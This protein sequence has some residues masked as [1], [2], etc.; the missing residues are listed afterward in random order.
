[1]SALDTIVKKFPPVTYVDTLTQQEAAAEL[2]SLRAQVAELR[3]AGQS[4]VEALEDMTTDQF[5]R[6]MDKAPRERL[7][8]ALRKIPA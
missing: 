3:E 1:M 2:A 4:M 6:G 7:Q 5:S 8:A